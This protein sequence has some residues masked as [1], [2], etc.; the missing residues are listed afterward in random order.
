MLLKKKKKKG[1]EPLVQGFKGLEKNNHKVNRPSQK[2]AA[3]K[4]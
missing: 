4:K 1:A 2:Q 3:P